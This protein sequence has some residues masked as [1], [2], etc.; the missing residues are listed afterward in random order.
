LDRIA[1]RLLR[2]PHGREQVYMTHGDGPREEGPIDTLYFYH[3]DHLGTPIPGL[4]TSGQ[5]KMAR[6]SYRIGDLAPP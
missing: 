6:R 3:D 5:L 1:G 4:N 2:R